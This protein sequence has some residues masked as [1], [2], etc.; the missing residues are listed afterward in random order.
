MGKANL[1]GMKKVLFFLV[2]P[3]AAGYLKKMI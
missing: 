1:M 3:K 2:N